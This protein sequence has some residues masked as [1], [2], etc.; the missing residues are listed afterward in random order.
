MDFSGTDACDGN[1]EGTRAS[2]LRQWPVQLH[3]VSPEAPYFKDADVLLAADC[4]AFSVGDFHKDHLKGNALAIAC[5]KLDSNQDIYR[6]KLTD[7][8]DAA[9]INTLS[10]MIMEVPCCMG[11]LN[12]AKS[13]VAA[14]GRKVPIKAKIVSL[15][16][17]ILREEWC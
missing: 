5:P 6:E 1:Q 7:L 9:N 14:A 17:E 15:R 16:G 12:L 13:A 4:V 8:I 2:Q 3:L 11:L 10:V